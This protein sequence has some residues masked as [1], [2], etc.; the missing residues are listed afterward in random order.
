MSHFSTSK[1]TSN[2]GTVEIFQNCL[3]KWCA[4]Q[5]LNL[6]PTGSKPASE[7]PQSVDSITY[8]PP[9]AP[10]SPVSPPFS[11]SNRTST[12]SRMGRIR[13]Y[14]EPYTRTTSVWRARWEKSRR[15][16]LTTHHLESLCAELERMRKSGEL[17]RHWLTFGGGKG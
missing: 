5:D 10:V 8:E 12:L 11:T 16:I 4:S 6:G 3:E 9:V 7:T 13:I 2:S 1:N 17:E 15:P 14:R